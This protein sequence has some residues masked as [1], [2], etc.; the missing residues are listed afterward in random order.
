MKNDLHKGYEI[1]SLPPFHG[2]G[3]NVGLCLSVSPKLS[4]CSHL[5]QTQINSHSSNA[6]THLQQDFHDPNTNKTKN[7]KFND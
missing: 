2:V 1:T 4:A 3:V 5:P 7:Q 6:R